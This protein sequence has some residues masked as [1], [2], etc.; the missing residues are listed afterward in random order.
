MKCSAKEFGMVCPKQG[1]QN[2]KK[3]QQLTQLNPHVGLTPIQFE[4][5]ILWASFLRTTPKG[6]RYGFI[7]HGGAS[8]CSRSVPCDRE[9]VPCTAVVKP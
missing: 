9:L 5:H 8:I 2:Y 1:N 7:L 6:L 4:K 3:N